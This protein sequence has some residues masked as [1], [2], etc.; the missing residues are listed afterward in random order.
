ML[1]DIPVKDYQTCAAVGTSLSCLV[2][3][4]VPGALRKVDTLFEV[5]G[6]QIMGISSVRNESD[7]WLLESCCTCKR[8]APCQACLVRK[9]NLKKQEV[10]K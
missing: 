3:V 5:I 10:Q 7:E 6:L 2:G 4:I 9:K 1:T 8:R